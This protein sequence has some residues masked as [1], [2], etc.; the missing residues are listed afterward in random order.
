ML[1]M[2]S[3]SVRVEAVIYFYCVT[4]GERARAVQLA[5][6]KFEQGAAMLRMHYF[7]R[8]QRRHRVKVALIVVAGLT[9]L[10]GFQAKADEWRKHWAVGE[11]PELHVSAG[12]AAVAIETGSND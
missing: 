4:R 1:P 6:M 11:R 5:A 7:R 3:D 9:V 8:F 10:Q 2:L 12:D